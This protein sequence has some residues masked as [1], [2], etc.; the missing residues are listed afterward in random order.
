MND[1][2]AIGDKNET[3]DII[4]NLAQTQN[5]WTDHMENTLNLRLIAHD[6]E[7]EE[8]DPSINQASYLCRICDVALPHCKTRFVCFLVLVK[9]QDYA[10]VRECKFIVTRLSQHDSGCRSA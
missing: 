7:N 5:Q 4:I 2:M 6:E 8:D 1:T 3:I 10:C 9:T